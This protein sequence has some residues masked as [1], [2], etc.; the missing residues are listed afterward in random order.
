MLCDMKQREAPEVCMCMPTCM[1]HIAETV[2]KQ[3]HIKWIFRVVHGCAIFF[4]NSNI[5]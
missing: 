5:P 3:L 1:I 2:P 4:S